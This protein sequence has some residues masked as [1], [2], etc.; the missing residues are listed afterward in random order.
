MRVEPWTVLSSEQLL[1]CRIF[2]IERTLA[3]SPVDRSVHEFFRIRSVDFAHVVPV[4]ENDEVVM[5]RQYRHGSGEM[6]L[7]VPAGLIEPSEDPAAAA[8]RE[9][10]EETGYATGE[11]R[12]LGMLRPNPAVFANNLHTFVAYGVRRVAAIEQTET[13]QTEVELVPLDRVA[14]LMI[15]GVIDNA[16]DVAVLWRFL[17]QRS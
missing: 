16:L 5:V 14:S 6:S 11:L 3:R 9:C 15:D 8:A 17:H 4:T 13:E 7:E 2:R 10:L 1:D 12:S